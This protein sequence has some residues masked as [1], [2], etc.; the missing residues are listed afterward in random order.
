MDENNAMYKSNK[1]PDGGE[2]WNYIIAKYMC[3][4]AYINTEIHIHI[5]IKMVEKREVNI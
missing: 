4:Y 3:I 2:V 5:S 1:Y